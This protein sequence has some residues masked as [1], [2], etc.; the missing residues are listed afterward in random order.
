M[1]EWRILLRW[2]DMTDRLFQ[3]KIE[4][5]IPETGAIFA[6]VTQCVGFKGE[7]R[8]GEGGEVADGSAGMDQCGDSG[9]HEVSGASQWASEKGC[10]TH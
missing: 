4:D 10:E 2:A 3:S 1:R 5:R 9:R 6:V 7:K 8:W